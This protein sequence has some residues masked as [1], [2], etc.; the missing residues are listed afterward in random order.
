M[1]NLIVLQGRLPMFEGK[2]TPANGDKK[3]RMN[4]A[5]NVQLN[6]KNENGYYDEALMNF[7]AWGYYADQLQQISSLPKDDATRKA[8]SNIE[9]SGRLVA[10]YRD[11]DGNIQNQVSIEVQE[12]VFVQRLPKAENETDGAFAPASAPASAPAGVP[13]GMP[14][15]A[16]GMG[17]PGMPGAPAGAPGMPG[18]PAGVPGV[19]GGTQPRF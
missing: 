6:T 2:Y 19:P 12:V 14:G 17:R 16:P 13:G 3:S 7:T 5:M 15:G 18:V 9:V 4:W 1:K 10:G 8:F 11:K